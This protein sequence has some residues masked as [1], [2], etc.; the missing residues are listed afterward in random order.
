MKNIYFYY[1]A[2]DWSNLCSFLQ[3]LSLDFY[4]Y[5]GEKLDFQTFLE[6]ALNGKW[7]VLLPNGIVPTIDRYGQIDEFPDAMPFYTIKKSGRILPAHISCNEGENAT[8]VFKKIKKYFLLHYLK[9]A[10]GKEYISE[11][12]FKSWLEYKTN[13]VQPAKVTQVTSNPEFFSF[14]N[15]VKYFRKK[16]YVICDNYY[17]ETGDKMSLKLDSYTISLPD[18]EKKDILI[19]NLNG[20]SIRKNKRK[21]LIVYSF[22]MDYRYIYHNN[23]KMLALFNEIEAYCSTV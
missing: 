8:S 10:F 21:G 22:T 15:F 16:G 12:C 13:L 3:S 7:F 4:T 17:A 20:V 19:G 6:N 18:V 14:E 2:A 11:T 5:K 23:E 9:T 1:D